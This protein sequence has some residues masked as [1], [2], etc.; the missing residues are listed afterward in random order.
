MVFFESVCSSIRWPGFCECKVP[1]LRKQFTE[2]CLNFVLPFR[3]IS[4]PNFSVSIFPE[5][6]LRKQYIRSVDC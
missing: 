1:L 6:F 2:Y 5:I 3:K 4:V